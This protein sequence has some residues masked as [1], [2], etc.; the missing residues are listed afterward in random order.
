MKKEEFLRVAQRILLMGL[1]I[2]GVA[3]LSRGAYLICPSL[4]W[5]TL[6]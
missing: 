2:C 1:E 5:V 4:G 6:A 3:A